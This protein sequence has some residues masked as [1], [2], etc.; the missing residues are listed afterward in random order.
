VSTAAVRR[1]V[2]EILERH[3]LSPDAVRAFA[4]VSARAGEP[5]LRLIAGDTL[6]AFPPE[7]LDEVRVPNRSDRV[8]AAV[9]T[10][11]VAEAAAVHGATVLAGSGATV[12]LIAEKLSGGTATAAVARIEPG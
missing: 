7:V 2:T 12:T 8:A 6:L 10:G 9:G 4:T 5:A 1:V 11:S 3:G